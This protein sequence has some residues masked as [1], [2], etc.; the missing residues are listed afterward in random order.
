MR[1]DIDLRAY[2]DTR[3]AKILLLLTLPILV[4]FALL[5]GLIQPALMEPA[6]SDVELT[7]FVLTLPLSLI[8]PVV[9]VMIIAGEWSDSSVQ[10]TF[11]Q[12]PGRLAV[13]GSKAIAALVMF[14]GL[15][16]VSIGLAAG[17][18]W[19]GGE[20]IGEGTVFSSFEGLLTTHLA[21]LIA[22]FLFSLAVAV[23]LQSTVI[24]L[25]IAIGVPFVVTT[26]AGLTM[27]FG[28]DLATDI[29]RAVDLQTAA[30]LA[31]DGEATAFELI[32]LLLLVVVPL[33]LGTRRWNLREVN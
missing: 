7:F 4:A 13:L 8:I 31:A 29:V 1:P 26:A 19:I 15:V 16:G 5:G 3:G 18:T 22:V 6:V 20:L 2:L 10:N 11:L 14:V 9:T 32:P 25:V 17:A 12:R 21:M 27:A 33:A 30:V 28:S 23:L 24:G